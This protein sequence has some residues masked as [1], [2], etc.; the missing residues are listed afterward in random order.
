MKRERLRKR[1]N[2]IENLNANKRK[3]SDSDSTEQE[4]R[5]VVLGNFNQSDPQ[6]SLNREV[7]NVHQSLVFSQMKSLFVTKDNN[8]VVKF[9]SSF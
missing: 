6:F 4:K 8:L 3:V 5:K 9:S 1:S 7:N 2:L